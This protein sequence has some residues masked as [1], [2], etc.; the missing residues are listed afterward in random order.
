MY[1]FLFL[2]LTLYFLFSLGL[3]GLLMPLKEAPFLCRIM[4][5]IPIHLY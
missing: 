3:L 2:F 4:L 5:E 1:G